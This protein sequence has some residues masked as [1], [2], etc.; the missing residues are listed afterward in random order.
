MLGTDYICLCDLYGASS[1]AVP[2]VVG[3]GTPH[4]VHQLLVALHD[5]VPDVVA[6]T[7]VVSMVRTPENR[8][9]PGLRQTRNPFPYPSLFISRLPLPKYIS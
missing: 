7:G 2:T 1:H 9:D 6:G 8:S 5:G 3:C 4:A